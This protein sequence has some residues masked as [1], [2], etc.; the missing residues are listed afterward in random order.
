MQVFVMTDFFF[1]LKDFPRAVVVAVSDQATSGM[2]HKSFYVM[3]ELI[4][5]EE[6]LVLIHVQDWN[7]AAKYIQNLVYLLH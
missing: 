3:Q 2:I 5:I 7:E 4:V 6:G 1:Y